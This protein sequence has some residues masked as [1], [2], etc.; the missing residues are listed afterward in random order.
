ML[1]LSCSD[2]PATDIA[3]SNLYQKYVQR[4][5]ERRTTSGPVVVDSQE[6]Q[7]I[8]LV[9]PTLPDSRNVAHN[10]VLHRQTVTSVIPILVCTGI[11]KPDKEN[12]VEGVEDSDTEEQLF[13]HGHRDFPKNDDLQKPEITCQDVSVAVNAILEREGWS[14]L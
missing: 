14:E 4:L 12:N 2:A 9:D 3:G 1:Y 10:A 7:L 11:Y 13:H 5:V 6:D 8:E